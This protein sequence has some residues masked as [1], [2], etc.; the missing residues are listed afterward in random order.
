MAPANISFASEKRTRRRTNVSVT[1]RFSSTTIPTRAP[2]CL[3]LWTSAKHRRSVL[4]QQPH[5]P[6][7]RQM[8]SP[9]GTRRP[10]V[11]R[12]EIRLSQRF[13]ILR[14]ADYCYLA[15]MKFVAPRSFADPELAAR[16]LVELANAFEPIQDGRIYIEKINGPFLYEMKGTPAEYKAGLDYAIAKGWLILQESGTFVKFTEAGVA[17]FA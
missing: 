9:P 14:G 4:C 17:L 12:S 7:L 6:R 8:R 10:A 16:R 13:A 5:Q 11:Q 1:I 15:V 2:D 3:S